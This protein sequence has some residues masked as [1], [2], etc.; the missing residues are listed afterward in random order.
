MPCFSHSTPIRPFSSLEI[1]LK[2]LLVQHEMAVL[3]KRWRSTSFELA[4]YEL[5]G[6]PHVEP[7]QGPLTIF[8]GFRTIPSP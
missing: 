2:L 3:D 8:S 4:E 7:S 6:G 1:F 5:V